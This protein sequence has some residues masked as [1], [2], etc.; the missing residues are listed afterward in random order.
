MR[1]GVQALPW[2]VGLYE[3]RSRYDRWH[4]YYKDYNAFNF[5]KYNRIS[6][7]RTPE[8]QCYSFNTYRNAV[9]HPRAK[10]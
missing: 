6:F 9:D 10:S 7:V 5:V 3:L 4:R 8:D 1:A 2:L